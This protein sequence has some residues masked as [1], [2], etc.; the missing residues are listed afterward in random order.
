MSLCQMTHQNVRCPPGPR[1]VLLPCTPFTLPT[2]VCSDALGVSLALRQKRTPSH[3]PHGTFS[4]IPKHHGSEEQP[5]PTQYTF[6]AWPAC[7]WHLLVFIS[8]DSDGINLWSLSF[9]FSLWFFG[10]KKLSTQLT[11]M[12][13][14]CHD[15]TNVFGCPKWHRNLKRLQSLG[16][17]SPHPSL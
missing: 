8:K 5:A 3:F 16:L 6:L 17:T 15:G 2:P 9:P 13:F 12:S 10:G 1:E 14:P 4:V 11:T 7:H